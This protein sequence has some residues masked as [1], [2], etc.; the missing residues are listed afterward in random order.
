MEENENQISFEERNAEKGYVVLSIVGDLVMWSLPAAKQKIQELLDCINS[1]KNTSGFYPEVLLARY[2]SSCLYIVNIQ[3]TLPYNAWVCVLPYFYFNFISN[4]HSW[5]L[6]P[7]SSTIKLTPT[8]TRFSFTIL[9]LS[10]STFLLFIAYIITHFFICV[11]VFY[12][13]F[14]NAKNLTCFL[15]LYVACNFM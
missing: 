10:Q 2:H 4:N 7:I 12:K 15:N 5:V 13:F 1:I 6:F 14:S 3:A 8:L 11:N 9:I